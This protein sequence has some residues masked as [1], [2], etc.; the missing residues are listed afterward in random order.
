VS[1]HDG[2]PIPGL[3]A[4]LPEGETIL[5]QGAPD[6][7]T[8]AR[9]AFHVRLLAG[10]FALLI[11]WRIALVL[12]DTTVP[13]ID[14]LAGPVILALIAVGL[15]CILAF[16]TARSTIYTI[17]SR[18]LVV[19]SGIALPMTVNYPYTVLT[20]VE[21]NE[22]ADGYGDVSIDLMRKERIGFLLNWPHVR[23]W[24]INHPQ[25]TLRSIA[26]SRV[27]GELLADAA[28]RTFESTAATTATSVGAMA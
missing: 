10:Y 12:G 5:W 28:S 25:P 18:R 13:A 21:L 15:V 4:A 19:R 6:W 22:F 14:A 20:A 23:P 7:R 1:D 16:L 26:A 8:L 24:H 11:G 3:P 17:T 27:V 2:E 9:R